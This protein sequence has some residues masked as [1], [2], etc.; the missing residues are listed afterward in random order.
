MGL[1]DRI[2][3]VV[4]VGLDK[5]IDDKA[6]NHR[7]VIEKGLEIKGNWQTGEIFLLGNPLTPEV[8][9]NN[10][11]EYKTFSWGDT[12]EKSRLT[13]LAILL[14]FLDEREAYDYLDAFLR[15]FVAR[16]PRQDFEQNFGYE[17]WRNDILSKRGKKLTSDKYHQA[18]L[19]GGYY[20]GDDD[21]DDGGDD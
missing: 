9:E 4:T 8:L 3:D 20:L 11:G 10:G 16:L 17:Y 15:D 6:V 14:W 1:L 13:A 12:S 18:D 7:R 19:H 2:L 5:I 21:A